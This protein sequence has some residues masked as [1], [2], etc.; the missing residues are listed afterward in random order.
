MRIACFIEADAVVRHFVHSGAF[1][2]LVQAHEVTFVFPEP[3][4]KRMGNVK[5]DQ[6]DLHGAPF[7]HL[8]VHQVRQQLWKPMFQVDR[9]RPRGGSQTKVMRRFI[10]YA[11]GPKAAAL[12]TVLALPG[13]YQ[14]F[15]HVSLRRLRGHPYTDLQRLLDDL[16]PDL[17]IHPSVMEGVYINDLVEELPRRNVPL[18]VVM[19]SWDNPSTKRAM[20]GHPDWLLVWGEQTAQHA[21]TYA[22]MPADR[23]VRFGAAQFDIYRDPPR[24][25][26]LTICA[27]HGIDPTSNILLYAGSSKGTDEFSH[28]VQLDEMIA[29]GRL[30]NTTVIY[31]PHPWGNGGYGGERIIAHPWQ[32][33]RIEA[34]MRGYLEGV[35]QGQHAKSLPDY[36]NTRDL[37]FAIDAM[38]SPLSTII[39]EAAALGKPAMCLVPSRE[40]QATHLHYT[41][42]QVHF[43]AL[44]AAPEIPVA[45]SLTDMADLLPKLMERVGDDTFAARLRRFSDFFVE[46]FDRPFGSRLVDFVENV[47]ARRDAIAA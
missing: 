40:L 19:N 22:G 28:L 43:E 10:R 21:V 35:A 24:A 5:A 6:L 17:V 8:Q 4:Y 23:V 41:M 14:A 32:N 1:R 16:N 3:G 31:R 15:R 2:E 30:P 47:A 36:R 18:I 27:D 7:R 42:P 44:F 9:L 33:V 34:S 29:D 20:I 46:P 11:I 12:Y 38:I 37:L 39:L 13:I 45:Q 25:D 26:R